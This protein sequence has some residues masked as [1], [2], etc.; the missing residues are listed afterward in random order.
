MNPAQAMAAMAA[1]GQGLSTVIVDSAALLRAARSAA[2]NV[3]AIAVRAGHNVGIRVSERPNG[4]RISV[5]GPQAKRYRAVVKA[6]LDRLR[7]ET[8]DDIRAQITRK[9]R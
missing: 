4:I 5:T 8:A 2:A 6:E 9:I 7:P 1:R 3:N